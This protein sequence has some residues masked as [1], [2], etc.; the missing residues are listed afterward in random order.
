MKP[1]NLMRAAR[2][3]IILAGELEARLPAGCAVPSEDLFAVVW[4]LACQLVTLRRRAKRD[5]RA[6]RCY[7]ELS[8]QVA[9]ILRTRP[10]APVPLGALARSVPLDPCLWRPVLLPGT[11]ADALEAA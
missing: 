7:R 2:E 1:K 6:A 5:R 10:D 3:A 11:T 8:A 4:P 9:E